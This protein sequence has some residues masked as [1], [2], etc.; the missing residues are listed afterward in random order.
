MT[1]EKWQQIE[2]F[3][4]DLKAAEHPPEL[5]REALAECLYS[6]SEGECWADYI[7]SVSVEQALM[8]WA[9]VERVR[10]DGFPESLRL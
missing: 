10:R 3:A 9:A 5:D 2:D 1:S 8:C 7:D 4:N 6:L